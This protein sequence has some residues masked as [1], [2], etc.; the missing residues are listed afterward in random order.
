MEER[1]GYERCKGAYAFKTIQSKGATLSF[2]TDWPAR[3][4]RSTRSVRSTACTRPSLD[5]PCGAP[6]RR[7]VPRRAVDDRKAIKAYTWG[8]AYASLG[9][10]KGMLIEGKLADITVLDTVPAR[11]RPIGLTNAVMEGED[12]L[13]D[14]RRADRLPALNI[15]TKISTKLSLNRIK[16][17][18][19][20]ALWAICAHASK[21]E[22]LVVSLL[23]AT[24]VAVA[25]PL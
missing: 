22:I 2:G 21:V 20:A 13:Y 24:Y 10:I 15:T 17:I 11:S 3:R 16:V 5:K 18:D 12:A 19:S 9:K 25:Y 14:R 1:I 6:R 8:S 23:T 7:L 4:P